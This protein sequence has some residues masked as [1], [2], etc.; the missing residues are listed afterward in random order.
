MSAVVAM[1]RRR[2][3]QRWFW[4]ALAILLILLTFGL[5]AV[6]RWPSGSNNN[7]NNSDK[8]LLAVRGREHP[9]PS[10]QQQQPTLSLTDL[11][12]YTGWARP[13]ATLAGHFAIKEQQ[14]QQQQQQH[15][16]AM[17]DQD[18]SI[19]VQCH[20]DSYCSAQQQPWFFV[21]AYG[22]AIV[23]GTV[24]PLL[25]SS[26]S[27]NNN[28]NNNNDEYKV[29]IHPLVPGQ[30]W[31]EVVLTYSHPIDPQHFPLLSTLPPPYYEG[32]LLPGFPLSLTVR[33]TTTT[34]NSKTTTTTTTTP[35][36]M[37]QQYCTAEQLTLLL[38]GDNDDDFQ[39]EW[40]RASWRVV[41]TNK[42][43]P[44]HHDDND[45]DGD[46]HHG[47]TSNVTLR[48]YQWGHNSLG[49]QAA[50]EYRDCRL[51]H[52]L[53]KAITILQQQ[54]SSSSCS[55]SS[56][57]TKT[58]K[59]HI[60]LIG[61]SVMRLQKDY[62]RQQL[63]PE[64]VDITF[65]ELYGGALR[66][67]RQSGPYV[68]DLIHG[69]NNAAHHPRRTVV[70]FNSGMHDIHRLCGPSFA[71]DRTTYLTIPDELQQQ[72][73]LQVYQTAIR[74]LTATVQ[75]IPAAVRLFQTTT[76]A[77]PKYGN[78]GVAWSPRYAQ[79]LP[80]DAHFVERFNQVA[81]HEIQNLTKNSSSSS[82]SHN[83][84]IAVVDAYWMTLARPDNRETNQDADIGKKLSHPGYE[85]VSFMV[86]VWWQVAVQLLL[87]SG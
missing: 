79:E 36:T 16:D 71:D 13:E 83:K 59:L 38:S 54:S 20:H 67:A 9:P 48:G 56:S 66:C 37:R 23:T 74:Q 21:R 77:W 31:L 4:M 75:Q 63:N 45:D 49:F 87:C 25:A 24:E 50:Y 85:V 39:Q 22:P 40:K 61:D 72:S 35:S 69:S 60:I 68:N 81:I 1:M 86:R 14:Q 8:V 12:G 57:F 33:G 70:L 10:A 34:S 52:D 42:Q 28:K 55:S 78:Y 44:Y 62:L 29:A 65:L 47:T 80:L 19:V 7:N 73:C 32:Y 53:T 3:Q 6:T 15:Y 11:P 43:T 58:N 26:S 76:A 84:P 17:V 64:M 82:N 30:Y 41:H 46:E 2:Y 5:G 51:H 18:W 27:N